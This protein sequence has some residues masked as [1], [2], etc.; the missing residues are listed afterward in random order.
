[1]NDSIS[2]LRKRSVFRI[3]VAYGVIAWILAQVADLVLD[4]FPAP[5]WVMQAGQQ[6]ARRRIVE[7]ERAK[8]KSCNESAT[9]LNDRK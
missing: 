8:I 4:A 9:N 2:E 6:D 5:D 3:G 1:M 7:D